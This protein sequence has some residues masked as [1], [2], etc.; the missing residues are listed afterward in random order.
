MK[1]SAFPVRLLFSFC[2]FPPS[3]FSLLYYFFF[4]SI[5]HF[6]NKFFFAIIPLTVM[7]I[8]ILLNSKSK[9]LWQSTSKPRSHTVTNR[10]FHLVSSVF[11]G[12]YW[13]LLEHQSSRARGE[14]S[15]GS[16]PKCICQIVALENCQA[17]WQETTAVSKTCTPGSFT[18]AQSDTVPSCTLA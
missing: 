2:L 16:L 15:F 3:C 6:F 9:L 7:L 14:Q 12:L 18:S 1:H 5:L 8:W 11:T 17:F 4:Y 10:L 13:F